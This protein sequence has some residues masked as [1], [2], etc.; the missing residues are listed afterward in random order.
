M[1]IKN[2]IFT[3]ADDASVVSALKVVKIFFLRS[4]G[5]LVDLFGVCVTI[6]RGCVE[7]SN[8]VDVCSRR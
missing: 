4:S 1:S 8:F 3:V 7:M 2:K 5:M 6:R